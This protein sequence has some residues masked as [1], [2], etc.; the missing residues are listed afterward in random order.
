M[1]RTFAPAPLMPLPPAP[2]RGATDHPRVNAAWKALLW[3]VVI[4]L[5]VTGGGDGA[6]ITS[7]STNGS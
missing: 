3:L 7:T 2:G 6:G 1:E 4:V 5:A